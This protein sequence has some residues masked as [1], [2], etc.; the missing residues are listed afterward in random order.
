MIANIIKDICGLV[1]ESA[2]W[3]HF[4]FWDLPK[5]RFDHLFDSTFLK[6]VF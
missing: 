4:I 2:F 5:T 6:A 3:S 1:N